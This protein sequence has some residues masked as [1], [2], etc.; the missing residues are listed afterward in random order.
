MGRLMS[1]LKKKILTWIFP[2]KNIEKKNG[3]ELIFSK[4]EYFFDVVKFLF[5]YSNISFGMMLVSYISEKH[6]NANDL[7]QDIGLLGFELHAVLLFIYVFAFHAI[8][9]SSLFIIEIARYF[10]SKNKKG[11]ILIISVASIFFVLLIVY[12]VSL[13]FLNY[14][15]IFT[16]SIISFVFFSSLYAI[17]V[18]SK[19]S[20]IFIFA[21]IV[22][23]VSVS[24]WDLDHFLLEKYGMVP[25]EHSQY[26][27][28]EHKG[29]SDTIEQIRAIADLREKPDPFFR[30]E[31]NYY[32]NNPNIL[33]AEIVA[34]DYVYFSEYGSIIRVKKDDV[35]LFGVQQEQAQTAPHPS[36]VTSPKETPKN[37]FCEKLKV[38]S[39]S[40]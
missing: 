38:Y 33:K 24:Y 17:Y 32:L 18:F 25:T 27:F 39:E 36:L 15:D 5:V 20:V 3:F 21:F 31:K 14:K 30:N 4:R 16:Y 28:K 37:N 29:T 19:S 11:K 7:I 6:I 22:M 10:C 1:D 26:L 34:G 35:V 9:S 8:M 12:S 23:F 13:I 2:P 40:K